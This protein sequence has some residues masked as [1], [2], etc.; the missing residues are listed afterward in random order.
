MKKTWITVKRGLLDPKHVVRLGVRFFLYLY[1]LDQANWETGEV[2]FYRDRDAADELGMPISTIRK[3]RVKLEE[4]KYI[5]CLQKKDHQVITIHN[6]TNPREYSGK[7]YNKSN[8]KSI[9]SDNGKKESV[10]KGTHKGTHKGITTMDT[11]SSNSNIKNHISQEKGQKYN[12]LFEHFINYCKFTRPNLSSGTFSIAWEKQIAEI[13]ILFDW[14]IK[15]AKAIVSKAVKQADKDDLR[16]TSP[17]S[18]IKIISAAAGK[19]K[20]KGVSAGTEFNPKDMK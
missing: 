7:V 17:K 13:L 9:L 11:P 12:E 14:D 8:Q 3:Q 15:K 6:W 20:R 16:I 4:D 10:H 18:L 1:Y 19:Q 2:L 5:S